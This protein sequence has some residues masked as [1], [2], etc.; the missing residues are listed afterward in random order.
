MHLCPKLLCGKA[1]G[2]QWFFWCTRLLSATKSSG[3]QK[4]WDELR[5]PSRRWER[6][7]SARMRWKQLRRTYLD[8]VWEELRWGEMRWEELRW[9]ETWW[10]CE[11][12]S[13]KYEVRVVK[14]ALWSVKKVFT[15]SCIAPGS[16]AGH[17]LVQQQ[18]NRLGTH[19]PG[20]RTA[21]ASS[22]DEKGLIV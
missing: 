5:R 14:G 15:W 13:V 11:V 7:I 4:S 9:D 2:A 17:V 1:F 18:C 6:L 21:H 22:I 16:R 8:D 19:G 12:R 20:W 3:V 10:E